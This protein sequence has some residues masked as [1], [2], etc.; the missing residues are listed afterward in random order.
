MDMTKWSH[1]VV[2]PETRKLLEKMKRKGFS[3]FN[4]A[5]YYCLKVC[6]DG[7]KGS[8]IRL[9]EMEAQT[10][11]PSEFDRTFNFEFPIRLKGEVKNE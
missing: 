3:S 9:S 7:T 1:V 2:K 10:L 11:P 6:K 4:E 8:I 5:I